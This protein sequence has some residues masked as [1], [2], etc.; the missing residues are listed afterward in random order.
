M[1]NASLYVLVNIA[2]S[3]GLASV[4]N[5]ANAAN[6]PVAP[7]EARTES[8]R[9]YQQIMADGSVLFTDVKSD[10]ALKT[11]EIR[12]KST[13]GADALRVAAQQKEHW[14]RENEAFKQRQAVARAEQ[15]SLRRDYQQA[16]YY[17][18][19]RQSDYG[20]SGPRV[21]V[22]TG[23]APAPVYGYF[24]QASE[25]LIMYLPALSEAA[26]LPPALLR[27]LAEFAANKL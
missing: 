24:P 25:L 10:A 4:L 2:G 15:D 16:L 22:G 27:S 7:V 3:L 6:K 12:Y 20:W 9:I 5:I 8:K 21:I 17:A 14:R 18:Q 11:S 13:A 26:L 19:S 1:N 23:F